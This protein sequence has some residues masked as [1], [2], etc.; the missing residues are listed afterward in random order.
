MAKEKSEQLNYRKGLK[1]GLPIGL[2]YLSVSIAF[3]VQA[4]ILG[5]P[6]FLSTLISLTNLTSAGQLAGLQVIAMASGG[7]FISLILEMIVSQLVINA[8]YF[9]MGISLSQKLDESFTLGKR[10]FYAMFI[11]DEIFAVG[12]SQKQVNTKYFLGLATL[13]YIGWALG[14]IIGAVA[15]NILPSFISEALGVALYAMFIAII[16]PPSMKNKGVFFAV[17][18]SAVL[19]CALYFIPWFNGVSTG[20]KVIICALV[21][22]IVMALVLPVKAGEQNVS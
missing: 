12:V 14:T 9:L 17:L 15:S 3:G 1:D 18:I 4:S 13:P 11:T 21:S 5:L 10:F 16:T 20:F 19:S 8:R 6:V 2:G 7:V 22:S